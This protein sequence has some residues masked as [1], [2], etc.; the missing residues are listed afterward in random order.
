MQNIIFPQVLRP[1]DKIAICAPAGKVKPEVVHEA[2]PVLEQQGW[3]VQIMPHALGEYGSFSGTPD[4]RFADL[5]DAFADPE[6]RAILCARGGYGMVHILDRLY[7]LPLEADPKWVIG[8]SDISAFHAL[9]G[10]KGIASLHSLMCA[11]ISRGAED[12]D[13]A[14]IFNILRGERPVHVFEG[15]PLDNPGI[16]TGTL[17]GGNLA[18]IAELIGTPYDLIKDDIILFIEDLNEP[19][20]KIER[21]LYQLQLKGVFNK[22]KGMIFGQFTEYKPDANYNDM[23]SMFASFM[24]SYDFPIAYKAPIGHVDHNIPLIENAQVTLKVA[25]YANNSIIF[26]R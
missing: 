15:H 3:K 16:A 13:I 1:G 20:Y 10:R 8:F 4:Q 5:R 26:H 6:V 7:S 23:E 14:S 21:I 11:G 19:I 24:R 22:I 12:A 9:M 2:V 18:V 17:Y 25:P